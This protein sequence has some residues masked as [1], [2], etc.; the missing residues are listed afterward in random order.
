MDFTYNSYISRELDSHELFL[1]KPFF[2]LNTKFGLLRKNR[3]TYFILA[4]GNAG[5]NT[6]LRQRIGILNQ[7]PIKDNSC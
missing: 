1:I 4:K 5:S 3:Y 7:M 6:I 2:D